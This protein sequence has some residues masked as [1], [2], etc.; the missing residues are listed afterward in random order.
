MFK[1]TQFTVVVKLF[2]HC[3]AFCIQ[4]FYVATTLLNA[5]VHT[6]YEPAHN[7]LQCFFLLVGDFIS[8]CLFGCM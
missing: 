1:S 3:L 4:Q 7:F 6:S 5:E 8:Y 2:L